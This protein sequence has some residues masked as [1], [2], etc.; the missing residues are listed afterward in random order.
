MEN[1]ELIISLVFGLFGFIIAFFMSRALNIVIFSGFTYAVFKTLEAL[2]FKIDWKL[3]NNFVYILADLGGAVL[4]LVNHMISN[5][6]TMALILFISGG[7]AALAL[8]KRGV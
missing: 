3:F 5:A 1:T 6:S 4:N 7:A 2:N 8:R